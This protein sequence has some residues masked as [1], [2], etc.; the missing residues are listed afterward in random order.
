[1]EGAPDDRIINDDKALH[2]FMERR[3]FDKWKADRDVRLAESKGAK[4]IGSASGST[5]ESFGF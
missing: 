1:M 3:K 4:T 5:S 2:H